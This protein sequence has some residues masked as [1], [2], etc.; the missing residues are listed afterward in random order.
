MRRLQSSNKSIGQI[1]RGV[2]FT[3]QNSF[4]RQLGKIGKVSPREYSHIHQERR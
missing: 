4:A 2:G 3:N 1:P